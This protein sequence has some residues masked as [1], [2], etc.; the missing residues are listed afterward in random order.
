M[1]KSL[2]RAAMAKPEDDKPIGK[3]VEYLIKQ[4]VIHV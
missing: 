4:E 3:S 2:S 1:L